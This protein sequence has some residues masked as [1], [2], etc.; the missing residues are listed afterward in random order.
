MDNTKARAVSPDKDQMSWDNTRTKSTLHRSFF[1]DLYDPQSSDSHSKSEF[2][3]N[4]HTHDLSSDED[5]PHPTT[6]N[7]TK[8]LFTFDE[9]SDE[10]GDTLGDTHNHNNPMRTHHS[11]PTQTV[12]PPTKKLKSPTFCP[13]TPIAVAAFSSPFQNHHDQQRTPF[14]ED[15]M[16]MDDE[17]TLSISSPSVVTRIRRRPVPDPSA[18]DTSLQSCKNSITTPKRSPALMC[19]PTPIQKPYHWKKGEL[20]FYEDSSSPCSSSE[21]SSLS[22]SADPETPSRGL[23]RSHSLRA[24]KLL[25]RLPHFYPKDLHDDGPASDPAS[26]SE[27]STSSHAIHQQFENLGWIGSGQFAEVY[28]VSWFGVHQAIIQYESSLIHVYKCIDETSKRQSYLC[29][30]TK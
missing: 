10:E 4:E 9:D 21:D 29:G 7:I 6:V 18:F 24:S 17:D 2:E 22:L 30:Q 14:E 20:S 25:L 26:E 23:T 15:I 5:Q 13:V 12:T 27:C 19:P 1:R 16:M 28:K 8:R 11:M 3:D